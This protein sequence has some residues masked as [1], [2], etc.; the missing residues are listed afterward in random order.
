MDFHFN[1]IDFTV[2]S[3]SF[4]LLRTLMSYAITHADWKH[5]L[6][7]LVL[8]LWLGIPLET[9]HGFSRVATIYLLSGTGAGIYRY[10]FVAKVK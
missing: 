1:L 7:N 9:V 8:Q 4:S 6:V 10:L 2:I 5:F 3:F